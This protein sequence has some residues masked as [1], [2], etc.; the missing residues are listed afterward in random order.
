MAQST[1]HK[2]NRMAG[3]ARAIRAMM[4]LSLASGLFACI[5]AADTD[6]VSEPAESQPAEG[7]PAIS[8]P[9]AEAEQAVSYEGEYCN[10][11]FGS[12]CAAGLSCCN[13]GGPIG[14]GYCRDLSTDEDNCGS[15]NNACANTKICVSGVCQCPSGKTWCA[16]ANYGAGGCVD[17]LNDRYNCGACGHTCYYPEWHCG[18]GECL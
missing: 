14:T 10:V 9:V 16:S 11:I 18:A 3:V 6:E 15:C 1:N 5:A 13:N 8:E 12:P 2:S 17:L 7:E 4:L